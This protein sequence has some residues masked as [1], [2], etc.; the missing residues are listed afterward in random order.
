MS[1]MTQT[2]DSKEIIVSEN[3]KLKILLAKC[4]GEDQTAFDQLYQQTSRHLHWVLMG[5]LKRDELA[6]EC[7]QDVYMKIWSRAGEYRPETAAPLTWM[8][9]IARNQAIDILR[10]HKREVIEADT[11]GIAEQVDEDGTPETHV[12]ARSDE[13][14]LGFCMKQLKPQHQQLFAL[15]YFKGLSHSELAHQLDMPVGT[16]KTWMRRGL[17]SL[18]ECMQPEAVGEGVLE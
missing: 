14:E 15:A 2:A 1:L 3:D 10:R 17:A 16:I 4:A 9:A 7:L 18:K 5:F 8:S 11:K 12:M 6:Q 13:S